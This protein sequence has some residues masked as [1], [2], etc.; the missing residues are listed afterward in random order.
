MTH[1]TGI[2]DESVRAFELKDNFEFAYHIE[3]LFNG[4]N[5]TSKSI[6]KCKCRENTTILWK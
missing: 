6:A 1:K 5:N 2:T 4:L 3:I